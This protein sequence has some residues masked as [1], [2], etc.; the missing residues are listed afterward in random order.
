MPIEVNE[1]LTAVW[2]NEYLRKKENVEI[3]ET[4]RD[5]QCIESKRKQGECITK[6][7][8]ERERFARFSV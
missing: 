8:G 6:K 1:V 5:P 2:E 4:F 3:K 7:R